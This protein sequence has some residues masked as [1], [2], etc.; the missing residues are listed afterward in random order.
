MG[1]CCTG[2]KDARFAARDKLLF[3][4]AVKSEKDVKGSKATI[5]KKANGLNGDEWNYEMLEMGDSSE[6]A[7]M[8]SSTEFAKKVDIVPKKKATNAKAPG[9]TI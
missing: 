6:G 7:K 5:K 4:R 8:D 9:S 3:L 1:L 2:D